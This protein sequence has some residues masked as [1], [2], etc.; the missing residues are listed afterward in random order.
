[1]DIRFL[2]T[3]VPRGFV[4][5]M[6]GLDN[7]LSAHNMKMLIQSECRRGISMIKDTWVT[8]NKYMDEQIMNQL[9]LRNKHIERVQ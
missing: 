1:M 9:L 6:N 8:T 2:S 3:T 7:N 4:E 5:K